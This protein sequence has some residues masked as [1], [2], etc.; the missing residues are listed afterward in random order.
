[1]QQPSL[2]KVAVRTLYE[3]VIEFGFCYPLMIV[4]E[5][6]PKESL[7]YYVYKY[8]KTPP[9]RS[10]LRLDPE[11]IAQAWGRLTGAVYR[12]GFIAAYALRNLEQYLRTDDQQCLA[13]FHKQVDWL[14][15]HAVVRRDGSVVW[16]H[17]FDLDEGP[18]RL[19]APWISANAQGLVIS[20]LVRAWRI[21]QQPRLLELLRGSVRVFQLDHTCDGV[22]IQAGKHTVYTEVPGLPAPGIMDGF[23][24]S[25]LGLY[26]LHT[27][28]GDRVV[29]R[30]FQEGVEGLR[31]FL[32][33]W[34]Y[35]K[36]WSM[37]SNR[38]Y[39]SPPGYHC[40]NRLLL[41]VLANLT[42]DSYLAEYAAAWNPDRL[43]LPDRAEIYLAFLLTKNAC[44]L[45]YRVWRQGK[46]ESEY[47]EREPAAAMAPLKY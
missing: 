42:G 27:E 34:D 13:V 16:E 37:Y 11:G 30:L 20:A 19:K 28:T 14:E 21:T 25:L 4:P 24:T 38:G 35:R 44:R 47:R 8:C 43:S 22:R 10:V 45:K 5:A 46:R 17:N 36:K 26:D 23:M 31:Y 9:Y 1:M 41:T 15:R 40:L 29:W 3:E 6:G 7:H 18:V 33:L 12:P 2:I 32:P 39:L